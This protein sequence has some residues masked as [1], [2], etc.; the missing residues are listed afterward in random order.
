V[1]V[2]DSDSEDSLAAR[3]LA[4]EHVIYPRAVRWFAEGRLQLQNGRVLVAGAGESAA[5]LIAPGG[6]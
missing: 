5:A 2:L 1:P 4:Q 3:V 6:G